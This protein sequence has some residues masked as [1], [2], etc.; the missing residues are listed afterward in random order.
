MA[1]RH[2]AGDLKGGRFFGRVRFFW[3]FG[4]KF[5]SRFDH[6]IFLMRAFV[7]SPPYI[8]FDLIFIVERR[9]AV[10]VGIRGFQ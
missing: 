2:V 4:G 6:A 8:K 1:D 7:E 10:F 3:S 5:F 9:E